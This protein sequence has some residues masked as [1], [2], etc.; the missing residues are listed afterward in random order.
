VRPWQHVLDCLNGYLMLADA[1]L[2]GGGAG[3]WNIG[4]GQESFVPVGTVADLAVA[5]WGDGASWINDSDEHPHEANLLALDA[6]KVTTELGWHNKL[7][8]P[9]SLEWTIEWQK[10]VIANGDARDATLAQLRAF[11]QLP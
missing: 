10:T 5:L 8:F 1:L 9:A 7:P 4:P 2:D 11:E 6:T 3:E